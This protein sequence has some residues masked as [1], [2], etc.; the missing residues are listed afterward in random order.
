VLERQPSRARCFT[1]AGPVSWPSSGTGP[2]HPCYSG[3]LRRSDSA[4]PVS[5]GFRHVIDRAAAPG[6]GAV[7][8][9]PLPRLQMNRC[10]AQFPRWRGITTR[11]HTP[12]SFFSGGSS[13]GAAQIH[14]GQLRTPLL[15]SRPRG[16]AHPRTFAPAMAQ[17]MLRWP[18]RLYVFPAWQPHSGRPFRGDG[19]AGLWPSRWWPSPNAGRQPAGPHRAAAN[20]NISPLPARGNGPGV[21]PEGFHRVSPDGVRPLYVRRVN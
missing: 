4:R 3:L 19:G 17:Y 13:K 2:Q 1:T 5:T 11:M 8:A 15:F 20:R 18:A 9:W 21:L 16:V 7:D 6:S 14:N 10:L 12:R